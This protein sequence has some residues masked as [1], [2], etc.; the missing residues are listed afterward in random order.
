MAKR[1]T[2]TPAPTPEPPKPDPP[3]AAPRG[4][5]AGMPPYV[6]TDQQRAMVRVMVAGGIQQEIIAQAIGI[7]RSTLQ[8]HFRTE[9]DS[10][11]GMANAQIV[12]ALFKECGTGNIRAIEFWLTNRD[13]KHWAHTQ[14]VAV[15]QNI[16]ENIGD[17][18]Q[19]AQSKLR[20]A[21]K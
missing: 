16:V 1:K 19:R 13:K 14:K 6:A 11:M 3:K 21:K 10:G 2:P 20:K 15:D 5:K 18:L 17:R 8:K 12:A 9:L 7:N 4:G